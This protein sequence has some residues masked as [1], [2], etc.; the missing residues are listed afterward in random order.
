[1]TRLDRSTTTLVA[2]ALLVAGLSACS[3]SAARDASSP[4][5]LTVNGWD[6]PDTA[7]PAQVTTQTTH[8][9]RG[10]GGGGGLDSKQASDGSITWVVTPTVEPTSMPTA[11][12]R[13]DLRLTSETLDAHGR[14]FVTV[15]N[16]GDGPLSWRISTVPPGATISP[17]SGSLEAGASRN[18]AVQVKAADS[19]YSQK[20]DVSWDEGTSSVALQGTVGEPP[21]IS[22][23]NVA[24]KLACAYSDKTRIKVS[25]QAADRGGVGQVVLHWFFTAVH[26]ETAS[27]PGIASMQ[28]TNGTSEDGR[29]YVELPF[30]GKPGRVT[31][32]V[33]AID[34]SGKSRE[35]E[36]FYI[37]VVDYC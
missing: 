25:A 37:S 22:D 5:D 9:R 19:Y 8:K 10:T 24:E 14:G 17:M 34:Y 12:P 6:S 11:T 28:R 4:D 18:L 1:M 35:A 30:N 13:G 20:L 7:D 3:H 26:G 33:E 21:T 36:R 16:A 29:W 15:G 23:V 27:G 31:A 2:G 32:W